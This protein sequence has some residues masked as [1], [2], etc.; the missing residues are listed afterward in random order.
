MM[1][2]PFGFLGAVGL[3]AGVSAAQA[4]GAAPTIAQVRGYGA[5]PDPARELAPVISSLT[6]AGVAVVANLCGS[7][8]DP[9][10]LD[11]QANQLNEAGAAVFLSNAAAATMA[12]ELVGGAA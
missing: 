12:A 4:Q 3:I 2:K 6:G 1:R 5:N 8:S 9:Q 7:R 11:S 10:G